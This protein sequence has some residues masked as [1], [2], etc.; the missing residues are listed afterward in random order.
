MEK[1]W[2][3][4]LAV[5]AFSFYLKPN[6]IKSEKLFFIIWFIFAAITILVIRLNDIDLINANRIGLSDIADYAMIMKL[7]FERM[8]TSF[9]YLRE[10]IVWFSLTGIYALTESELMSF[11]VIDII[12]IYFL[13]RGIT[14]YKKFLDPVRRPNDEDSLD[15]RYIY[16]ALF[17]F[18]PFALGMHSIYRQGIATIFSIC[19]IGFALG[20][21]NLKSFLSFLIAFLSHNVALLCLPL[22]FYFTYNHEEISDKKK[23][24]LASIA[25]VLPLI[26]LS[27][28]GQI[29]VSNLQSMMA[30]DV[31]ENIA[32][33]YAG[34]ICMIFIFIVI[35]SLTR[36]I[37]GENVFILYT[38]YLSTVS[39]LVS[40]G[41]SSGAAERINIYLIALLLPLITIFVETRIRQRTITRLFL[42]ILMILPSITYYR[43]F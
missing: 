40:L 35:L 9:I 41:L 26:F 36:K 5:L 17:L 38:F 15:I 16:F 43:I 18:F 4:F 2:Y 1:F 11:F 14:M 28:L 34:L 7:G 31:G 8:I 33:L 19:S 10:P 12:S 21:K 6:I 29:N 37:R 27:L 22:I 30:I 20:N 3:L 23:K 24:I 13:Y 42:I 39:V 25:L 32:Y